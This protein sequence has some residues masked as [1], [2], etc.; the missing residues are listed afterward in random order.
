M[1][2]A[3]ADLRAF[4]KRTRGFF[5][6]LSYVGCLPGCPPRQRYRARPRMVAEVMLLDSVV[7]GVPR[8]CQDASGCLGTP[9]TKCLVVLVVL[10]A[11][12]GLVVLVLVV[13]VVV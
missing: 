4:L 7:Y 9:Y 11:L 5:M 12:G 1:T 3:M 6:A 10:V 13:H 8:H 2:A